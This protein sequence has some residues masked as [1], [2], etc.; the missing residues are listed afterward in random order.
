ML[1]SDGVPRLANANSKHFDAVIEQPTSGFDG[2]LGSPHPLDLDDTSLLVLHEPRHRKIVA[3]QP[4][5]ARA[6]FYGCA[7]AFCA[8]K[9]GLDLLLR[10]RC[11]FERIG[12]ML[13]TFGKLDQPAIR[14]PAAFGWNSGSAAAQ[15]GF[16][17]EVTNIAHAA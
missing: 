10:R 13:E 9:R 2:K 1:L 3:G 8:R 15:S 12:L 7:P 17:S 11:V 6:Y 4:R 14:P 16:S 5:P